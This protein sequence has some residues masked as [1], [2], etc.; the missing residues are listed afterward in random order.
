MQPR[1]ALR[2]AAAGPSVCAASQRCWTGPPLP[3]PQLDKHN[4][5]RRKAEAEQ[6]ARMMDS[7]SDDSP[8]NPRSAKAYRPSPYRGSLAGIKGYASHGDLMMAGGGGAG[9]LSSRLQQLLGDP[10]LQ[11]GQPAGP[12]HTEGCSAGP[13]FASRETEAWHHTTTCW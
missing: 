11:V 4:E 5:R 12:A 1:H 3:A 6:K 8:G 10:A 13:A 2:R 9:E 7:G